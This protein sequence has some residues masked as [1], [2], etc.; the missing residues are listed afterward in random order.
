MLDQIQ[1]APQT[2]KSSKEKAPQTD[3]NNFNFSGCTNCKLCQ[4]RTQVVMPTI[5]ENCTIMF[6]GEAPGADEDMYG[7]PFI[8]A[9]G[10]LLDRILE[11]VG[12]DRSKCSIANVVNCRPPKNRVPEK[13]E[14]DACE[15]ILDYWIKKANPKIIVPL[16]ATALKRIAGNQKITKV[17]G[18][19]LESKHYPGI[20]IVPAFH[21]SFVLRDPRNADQ[22]RFALR[23]VKEVADN[24]ENG[25]PLTQL[26]GEIVYVNTYE[27][28]NEMLNALLSKDYFALDI[29]TDSFYWT[30]GNIISIG[31]SNTKGKSYVIPWI[32]GDEQFYNIC[33]S[34]VITN[35]NR[36][37]IQSV[38]EF[39]RIYKLN[40]PKY[41]WEGTDVKEKLSALLAYPK[42][43]K[44]LHNYKFDY[45]FLEKAG[46]KIEGP[47]Y[48]TMLMHHLLDE[49]KGYHGLD[50]CCL[51]YTDYGEYW[52]GLDKYILKTEHKSDTYAI[53]PIDELVDY[54]GRDADVTLQIFEVFYVM[55]EREDDG[56]LPLLNSFLMPVGNMLMETE[57][58]GLCLDE[59]CRYKTEK[60]L[61]GEIAK[62]DV[63]LDE[64]SKDFKPTPTKTQEKSGKG[65]EKLN[66]ASP[67]QLSEFLFRYLNLPSITKTDKGKD[68]TSEEALEELG[69]LHEFP[70]LLLDRRKK[71][72]LLSTYVIG[73][74]DSLWP[75]GKIHCNFHQVGTETGRLSSSGPNMQNIPRNNEEL[76]KLGVNIKNFIVSP[77]D[78]YYIVE[79]DYSQAEL[80]LIAEYSR[81]KN[82]YGAFTQGRDPHAELAL[83]LFH[84]ERV[85]EMEAGTIRAEKI[86]TKEQRQKGK[87]ANFSLCYG[88]QPKNFAEEQGISFDEACL[89]YNVYWQTYQGIAEWRER[90]LIKA[91][92]QEHLQS[93]F[94]RKRRVKKINHPDVFLRGEAEREI[95]NFVIQSQASDYTLYST[96]M[97]LRRCKELGLRAK[98]ILF[99]HD[100]AVYLV[101]KKDIQTFLTELK[102]IMAHP[103]GITITM[104]SDVK[105]GNRW[106]S[107]KEW[108]C[109]DGIWAEKVKKVA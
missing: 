19:L 77:D 31:F 59:E 28:F 38:D 88:K 64:L 1:V 102:S 51:R 68:S 99:V 107:L 55:L 63:R 27:K 82:L 103:P 9:S 42:I 73:M 71:A 69:K 13:D 83:R 16:G 14:I 34:D 5:V 11:E 54:N 4:H 26:K 95:I 100:S 44:I 72:K 7:S 61:E 78:D 52:K 74:R 79:T 43:A 39:C 84:K 35:R 12:I 97:T 75:D 56:F 17:N 47:I 58:E 29:E 25:R 80:R 30:H 94:R 60:I 86:V 48:D 98:T 96:L 101:H 37:I 6:V 32:V 50:N 70:K 66:F 87:T 108:V 22:L 46:L 21:P 18:I 45:K 20:Q 105:V 3:W 106:G 62:L 15:P 10:Q 53:I 67:N 109:T 92:H 91:R 40:K 33:R 2:K 76:E 65:P 85:P 23:R 93:Y 104:E 90:E 49:Q 81:D 57:K 36:D 24:F 89:T 41:F 8:G